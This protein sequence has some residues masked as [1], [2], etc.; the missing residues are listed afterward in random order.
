MVKLTLSDGQT[1]QS[2]EQDDLCDVTV[3]FTWSV[4]NLDPALLKNAKIEIYDYDSV[5]AHDLCVGWVGDFSKPGKQT[6]SHTK[7]AVL[8]IEVLK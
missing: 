1:F 8:K 5:D 2:T 3:T 6:F 7:K 4:P